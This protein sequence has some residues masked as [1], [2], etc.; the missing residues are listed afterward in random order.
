M[1]TP[2][3][4][5]TDEPEQQP[6]SLGEPQKQELLNELRTETLDRRAAR[7]NRWLQVVAL[8]LTFFAVGVALLGFIGLQQFLRIS[9]RAET[10]LVNTEDLGVQHDALEQQVQR[11]MAG[12]IDPQHEQKIDPLADPPADIPNLL[13]D[14]GFESFD[15]SSG[16]L[17]SGA[18]QRKS[19]SLSP[20]AYRFTALCDIDCADLDLVLYRDENEGPI[21]ED[22][23]LD[24]FPVIEFQATTSEDVLLEVVMVECSEEPCSW[25]LNAYRLD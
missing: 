21:A 16:F 3:T 19:F 20:G 18:S 24:S 1:T 2:D 5:R 13:S 25:Y 23:L 12:K 14:L 6:V 22:R 10:A 7:L 15:A 17:T 9:Q 11:Y 8:F 4:P